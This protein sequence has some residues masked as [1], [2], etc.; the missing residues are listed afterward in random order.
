[1]Q[2]ARGN[3]L[4]F[5]DDDDVYIPGHRALMQQAIDKH[6][7]Q[8][9][10]FRMAYPDGWVLWSTP[11]LQCGNVSTQMMLLPNYPA[12]LG[13]WQSG[14][15]ECD[16]DFLASSKWPR[17]ELVWSTDLICRRSEEKYEA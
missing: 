9:V 11:D 7:R 12:K 17:H 13:S 5:M 4:A 16:F 3:H 6:P 8:P 14:R 2:A 1:M 10:I 15:R